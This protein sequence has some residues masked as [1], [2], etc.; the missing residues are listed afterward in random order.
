MSRQFIQFNNISF[1]YDTSEKELF[2]GLSLTL[3]AGWTGIAGPNGSGKT[4]L[5][6]LSTGILKPSSGSIIGTENAFLCEQR[7]DLCP[8]M[9]CDFIEAYGKEAGIIRDRLRIGA[10]WPWRWETLSHGERKRAQIAVLL[11]LQP[12]VL[13]LDEPTNHLDFTAREM[14]NEALLTYNGIGLLVSHDRKLMDSMCSQTLFLYPPDAVLRPGGI[15]QGIQ[16]EKDEQTA[17]RKQKSVKIKDLKKLRRE[18]AARRTIAD[19]SDSR[20]SKK[21]ISAKDHSA[22][23]KIDRARITGK[24]STGGKLL[25]QM[26]SRIDRAETELE[27]IKYRR[28]YRTGIILAGSISVRNSLLSMN[29]GFIDLGN[30]HNLYYPDLNIKPEDRIS[31]TGNNGCGKSTLIKKI[32][33]ELNISNNRLTYIPQEIDISSSKEILNRVRSLDRPGLGKLMSII[34]CLGSRPERLLQSSSP[35]PGET[36]KIL[37]A[38]GMMNEPHIIVMDEPT[39]HMDLDSITAIEDALNEVN[40]SLLLV[41]H[42]RIFLDRLTDINWDIAEDDKNEHYCLNVI[43]K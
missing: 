40:C 9:L 36:R 32:I 41:S 11:W 7:T 42:D 27:G 33:S 31:I 2:S 29:K 5:L 6:M 30:S 28:N 4:T 12:D 8:E 21:N 3:P 35:S 18:S 34:S 20:V 1:S 17:I 24:D 19:S 26:K 15:T 13:A 38:L 25:N 43:L 14:I 39:N 10:D 16:I 23:D 22:K 37:L